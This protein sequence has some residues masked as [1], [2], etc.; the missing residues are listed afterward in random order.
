MIRETTA[1]LNN[2][3]N[4]DGPSGN[5]F[6]LLAEAD[7]HAQGLGIDRDEIDCML[8]VM[9]SGDYMYLLKTMNE[10][11]GAN[12]DYPYGIIFETTNEEL[13]T[14]AVCG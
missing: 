7:M 13:L 4:L 5:A 12:E 2:V 8:D 1:K 3:I 11:V 6:A 9:K 14:A 10:W